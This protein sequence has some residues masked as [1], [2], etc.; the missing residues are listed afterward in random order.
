MNNVLAIPGA[1]GQVL[2]DYCHMEWWETHELRSEIANPTLPQKHKELLE[3]FRRELDEAISRGQIT[4]AQ[5]E[6]VTADECGSN[7]E[8]VERLKAIRQEVFGVS[9][10]GL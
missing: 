2:R 3:A 6:A 8:V 4:P 10:G 9:K 7:A 1:L 5:F